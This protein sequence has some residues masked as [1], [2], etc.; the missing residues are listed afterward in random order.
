MYCP[1]CGNKVEIGIKFCSN[2]GSNLSSQENKQSQQ[3]QSNKILKQAKFSLWKKKSFGWPEKGTLTLFSDRLEW[4]G[5]DDFTIPLES[6]VDVS[7]QCGL[8]ANN[9]NISDGDDKPYR[10][11]KTEM[12]STLLGLADPMLA[13]MTNKGGDL[14]SWRELIEKLRFNL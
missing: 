1:K 3:I 2:C 13:A 5:S 7:V 9:L 11:Q 6:I 14:V 4:E 12:G 8:G 10:F